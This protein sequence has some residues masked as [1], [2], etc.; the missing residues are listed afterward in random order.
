MTLA[1][2]VGTL[3]VCAAYGFIIVKTTG[4]K[5]DTTRPHCVTDHQGTAVTLCRE[6]WKPK[7]VSLPERIQDVRGFS[8]LWY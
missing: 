4:L 2:I 8:S 1:Y 3:P 6:S 5:A 7:I